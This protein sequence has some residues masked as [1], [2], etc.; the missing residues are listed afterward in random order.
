MPSR[1]CALLW[2]HYF[3]L[4]PATDPFD[5]LSEASRQAFE[6]APNYEQNKSTRETSET[7]VPKLK[8]LSALHYLPRRLKNS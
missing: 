8:S 6:T 7:F 4:R 5:F 1:T 2:Y 3:Q